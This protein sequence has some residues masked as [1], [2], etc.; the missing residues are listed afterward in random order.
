MCP[1][2]PPGLIAMTAL[3]P[4]NILCHKPKGSFPLSSLQSTVWSNLALIK[5]YLTPIQ[6]KGVERKEG[7]DGGG[8]P[9]LMSLQTMVQLGDVTH[10]HIRMSANVSIHTSHCRSELGLSDSDWTKAA[11]ASICQVISVLRS[12]EVEVSWT[13]SGELLK[14]MVICLVALNW[15][16]PVIIVPLWA[17][18][19]EAQHVNRLCYIKQLLLI[20]LTFLFFSPTGF[21]WSQ[22]QKHRLQKWNDSVF[23]PKVA[24]IFPFL[25]PC[26]TTKI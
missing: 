10:T 18:S 5:S 17:A 14:H 22:I 19:Q 12:V 1:S 16:Y 24:L 20:S 7:W 15:A 21:H 26:K 11:F 9:P 23:W 25:H 6:R 3:A 13:R 4:H 2:A 8:G